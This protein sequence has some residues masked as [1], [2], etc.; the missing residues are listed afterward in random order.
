[1]NVFS[2]NEFPVSVPIMPDGLLP[3]QQAASAESAT[4]N[5]TGKEA[6]GLGLNEPRNSLDQ[7]AE[8]ETE[9]LLKFIASLESC[10]TALL[11]KLN[12]TERELAALRKSA[13]QTLPGTE[14]TDDP[15]QSYG[16]ERK[17]TRI[18]WRPA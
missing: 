12:Q 2:A 15:E 1:M 11:N 13:A 8:H 5:F 14:L 7:N 18:Q 9:H 16:W 6:G 4:P 17:L 3:A 10:N